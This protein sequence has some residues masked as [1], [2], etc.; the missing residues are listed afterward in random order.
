MRMA[1]IGAGN[2]GATLG[3]RWRAAGHDVVYG[4]RAGKPGPAGAPTAEVVAAA[5]GAEVVLLAVPWEA[6]EGVVA[7]VGAWDGRI[8]IDATNPIGP[9]FQL[10]VGRTSSGAERLQQAARGARVVKAFNTVGFEVMAHPRFLAGN[11]AMFVAGDDGSATTAVAG[12][13]RDLGFDAVPLRGLAQARVLEPLAMLWISLS[14]RPEVGRDFALGLRHRSVP[15]RGPA[16][17]T[18]EPRSVLVCGAGNIGGNLARAWLA[19]GHHVRIATRDPASEEVRALTAVG[20]TAVA[21][22]GAAEGADVVVLAVPAAAASEVAK[23]LGP[24]TGKVVIDCTN[25]IGKGFVLDHGP[26]TSAAEQLASTLPGAHVVKA[27]NQQGAEVL[28][29]PVFD[30]LPAVG[31]LA[32][33]DAGARATASS[34]VSDAGLRPMDAGPL[35]AARYLEPLTLVWLAA[36]RALST[37]ELGFVLLDRRT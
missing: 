19:A 25:A 16:R 37:R 14:R 35:A 9:G 12:L 30:G 33:D 1:I 7:E 5:R 18:D 21:P 15:T 29:A 22:P 2:V 23:G 27:F 32:G 10:A 31:F 34:L 8:L 20:A 11:A 13:A 24:L 28:A 26:S 3:E 4:L 36:S 6:A 17:R